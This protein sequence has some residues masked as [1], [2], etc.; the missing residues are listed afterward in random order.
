MSREKVSISLD[1]DE[2]S[3]RTFKMQH[4]VKAVPPT[5]WRLTSFFCFHTF[6][7]YHMRQN[8]LLGESSHDGYVS[9]KSLAK[10]LNV[11]C[12]ALSQ[13][14]PQVHTYMYMYDLWEY[15]NSCAVKGHT[16]V[17]GERGYTLYVMNSI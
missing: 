5:L 3:L 14:L 13:A 4:M 7:P 2:K 1:K 11:N 12:I 6:I 17:Q 10:T 16:C 9:S 8:L 15:K